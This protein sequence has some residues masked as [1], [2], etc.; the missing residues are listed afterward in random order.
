MSS[1]RVEIDSEKIA[2][3]WLDAPGKRVN[4]LS[5][6]MWA[7]LASAIEQIERDKPAGAIIASA[8][9]N[10]FCVG[11]DLYEIRDMNDEEFD[12]YIYIGQEILKRLESLPTATV[13]A[14]NGDCI[15]GGFE[16]ALACTE[17][18]IVANDAKLGLPEVGLGLIP[19][20]G[21]TVRLPRLIGV[22]GFSLIRDA[23]LI[24]VEEAR[25][26][27]IVDEPASGESPLLVAKQMAGT[28]VPAGARRPE[29]GRHFQQL[30][31]S[32]KES[33]LYTSESPAQQALIDVMLQ[34]EQGTQAGYDAE[35]RAIVELRRSLEGQRL[36][37]A[38]FDRQA[39]K[40]KTPPTS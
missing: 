29:V 14:I 4:T 6:Q 8:K 9:A 3:I 28:L 40:K 26:Y 25:S 36:L 35:R 20:W 31:R 2:T 18:I 33:Y 38:F 13:A 10:S 22:H 23:K 27:R 17:R 7:D 15:G 19:G 37:Q 12:R 39:A 16:L 32:M 11:A 21:G 24:T 5:R 30:L 1:V 34:G